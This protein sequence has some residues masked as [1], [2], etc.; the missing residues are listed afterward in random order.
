M[1]Q[2]TDEGSEQEQLVTNQDGYDEGIGSTNRPQ[3]VEC[4]NDES[5]Y[6]LN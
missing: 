6:E 2:I 3:A 4:L 5:E 1:N